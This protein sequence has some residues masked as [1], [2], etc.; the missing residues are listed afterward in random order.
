MS[1]YFLCKDVII[2]FH[3]S[4]INCDFERLPVARILI[5]KLPRRRITVDSNK[6]LVPIDTR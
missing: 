5:N 1:K 4:D 6:A 3:S 2:P